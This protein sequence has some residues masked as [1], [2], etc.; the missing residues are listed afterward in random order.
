[1]IWRWLGTESR[2]HINDTILSTASAYGGYCLQSMTRF[3]RVSRHTARTSCFATA[4][5]ESYCFSLRS[6][7]ES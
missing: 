5:Q 4:T 1:M 2:S 7:M 3:Q 6:L